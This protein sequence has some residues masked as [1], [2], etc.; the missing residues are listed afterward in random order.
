MQSR[1]QPLH[2]IAAIG[3]QW[4]DDPAF[5]ASN[6]VSNILKFGFCVKLPGLF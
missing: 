4:G 3:D 5:F 2:L 1:F 6:S